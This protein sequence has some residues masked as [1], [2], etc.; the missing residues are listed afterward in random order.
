[1]SA[2]PPPPKIE[3]S[4][5]VPNLNVFNA[6]ITSVAVPV[7]LP[8]L[9]GKIYFIEIKDPDTD[10]VFDGWL[11]TLPNSSLKTGDALDVSFLRVERKSGSSAVSRYKNPFIIFIPVPN[12]G[13]S[14]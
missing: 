14:E 13:E 1:M 7:D 4:V 11:L 10:A 3:I 9:N 5:S 8:G 6:T 12:S 2:A